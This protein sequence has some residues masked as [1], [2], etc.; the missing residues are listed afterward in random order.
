MHDAWEI[1]KYMAPGITS[2]EIDFWYERARAQ[3][4][5]G[6]K[7]LGAGGG[8]FLLLYAPL[9]HHEHIIRA[10]P[11]LRRIPFQFEPQGSKIIYV[12]EPSPDL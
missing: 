12:E 5:I 1:K 8:G 3:G 11:G 7:I 6:G 2:E 10:L 9:I 4:A